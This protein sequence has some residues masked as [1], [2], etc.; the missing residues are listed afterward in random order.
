[1]AGMASANDD[2]AAMLR[3]YAELLSITGGDP[4]RARNYEKAA[5]A[6]AGYPGD[7]AAVPDVPD[8]GVLRRGDAIMLYTDG[9]VEA[10]RQDIDEGI[11]RLL[12]E[13]QRLVVD[14]FR[15]GAPDLVTTM[16][17]TVN[18]GDDCALVLVWR[19]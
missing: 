14:G 19:S 10:P 2:A 13:A 12:G 11:Q 16:Q 8:E 5:K 15:T 3:E 1:M 7:L 4:F 6:V 9:L 18:S 17:R